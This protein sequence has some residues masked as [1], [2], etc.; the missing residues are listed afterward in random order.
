MSK[1]TLNLHVVRLYQRLD[2]SFGNWRLLFWILAVVYAHIFSVL[3][4]DP[5][6]QIPEEQTAILKP[7]P[8]SDEKGLWVRSHF[9]SNHFK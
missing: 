6:S 7:W 8:S 9:G 4:F 5:K 3:I 2:A 1:W